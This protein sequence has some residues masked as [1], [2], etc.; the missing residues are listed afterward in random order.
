M[1][2]VRD[3]VAT[4]VVG[5]DAAI[6]DVLVDVPRARTR[7][8][9]RRA[10]NGEDAAR[11]NDRERDGGAIHANPVHAGSH[12]GRR[13]RRRALSRSRARLRVSTG[14]GVHGSLVGGRDQSRAGQDAG[15]AARGDGRTTGDRRRREPA[16]RL[17]VHGAG[18]AES[19]RARGHVSAARSTARSLSHED[20]RRLSAGRAPS[21]RCWRCTSRGSIPERGGE[22]FT[23]STPVLTAD[24]ARA[25]RS[26]VDQRPRRARE[27]AST[28]RR[29]RERRARI[30]RWCSA[31]RRARASR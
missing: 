23:S 9:R 24:E 27:S 6:E 5:Q 18:D 1:A 17:A 31:R 10:G 12:A 7:A 15:G 21:C 20:R 14:S 13:H 29:S 25:C 30:R 2:R 22:A 4:R 16:A 26:L 19:G 3:A 11:A 8:D 28:S